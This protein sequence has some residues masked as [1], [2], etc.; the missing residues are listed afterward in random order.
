MQNIKVYIIAGESS[1]DI[2]GA[3][4][5]DA[6][7]SQSTDY[8]DFNGIGGDRM[9]GHGLHSLFPMADISVMGF[10]EIVPHIPRVLKR[11]KQTVNDILKVRPDIVITIDSPGFCCRVAER[12]QG[13]GIKII[14]YVAP[15]VWAYKPKR[16]AKFARLFN[17]ILLLLPFEAPYFDKVGLANTY[18]GHPIIEDYKIKG[19]VNKF[20][21]KHKIKATEKVLCVMP[22]SRITE[23]KKLMPIFCSALTKIMFE[24]VAVRPVIITVPFLREAINKYSWKLPEKTLIIDSPIEKHDVFAASKAALA[25]SGT[26]TLELS[27]ARVPLVVTYKSSW[28]SYMLV[29]SFIKVKYA[30]LLNLVKDKEIIP[31]FMQNKCKPEL[32]AN[33]TVQLLKDEIQAKLQVKEAQEALTMLGLGSDM[34]PSI[35]A[36][37]VVL[38]FVAQVRAAKKPYQY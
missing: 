3:K 19:D 31:E 18:V 15:T 27:L 36:A 9:V 33:A 12:L 13:K 11:I 6:L 23:I 4:L 30:N 26:G 21:T 34:S 29:K 24:D 10:A 32:L 20:M 22:G 38:D 28:I 25:K 1:G 16:A 8:M 37:R 2:L 35:K 7:R 5:M 14:H 17:H